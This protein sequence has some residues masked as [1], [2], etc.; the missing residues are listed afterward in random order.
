MAGGADIRAGK[1]FVEFY[2]KNASFTKGI[3]AIQGQIRSFGAGLGTIGK[4]MMVAGLAIVAPILAATKSWAGAGDEMWRLSKTTG[5]AVEALSSLKFAANE[6]SV[7]T[8]NLAKA[9]PKM[10]KFMEEAAHGG[11]EQIETLQQLGLRMAD[12]RAMTPDEQFRAMAEAISRIQNPTL[13]VAAA[14]KVF[15]KSGAELLPMFAAGRAGIE[16]YEEEARNLGLVM[17]GPAAQAAHVLNKSLGLIPKVIA[18][19]SRSIGSVLAP[20][21]QIM[22]DRIVKALPGFRAWINEHKKMV[23]GIAA[24]AFAFA[25]SGAGLFILGK[26]ISLT[27]F[28][29]TP[30]KLLI[31]VM[32]GIFYALG[33][34][35]GVATAAFGFLWGAVKMILSPIGKVFSLLASGAVGAVKLFFSLLSSGA[36]GGVKA[37][38]LLASGVVGAVKMFWNLGSNVAA[39]FGVVKNIILRVANEIADVVITL[40]TSPFKFFANL[41]VG[42]GTMATTLGTLF[43]PLAALA[44]LLASCWSAV[45]A[46]ASGF[47]GFGKT[48]KTFAENSVASVSDGLTSMRTGAGADLTQLRGA[49]EG[50]GTFFAGWSGLLGRIWGDVTAAA[51]RSYKAFGEAIAGMQDA[52]LA[53]DWASMGPILKNTLVIAWGEIANILGKNWGSLID[54]LAKTGAGLWYAMSTGIAWVLKE[55]K[56]GWA[57]FVVVAKR[58]WYEMLAGVGNL[59]AKIQIGLLKGSAVSREIGLAMSPITEAVNEARGAAFQEIKPGKGGG[60]SKS[61]SAY[62]ATVGAENEAFVSGAE[63]RFADAQAAAEST[64]ARLKDLIGKPG[65]PESDIEAARKNVTAA[66]AQAKAARDVADAAAQAK[67]ARDVAA[68]QKKQQGMELPAEAGKSMTAGTF[69]GY[70]LSMMGMGGSA[71]DRTAAA[72]ERSR[73]I[74]KRIEDL[75]GK[76][77]KTDVQFA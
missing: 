49:F 77:M 44:L 41:I 10:A 55:L 19:I 7:E 22:I 27:T 26:A 16:A 51:Q 59:L 74:L 62:E 70:A 45:K 54:Q 4:G 43:F 6:S 36:V 8:E 18:S 17:S 35:V 63:K 9:F 11:K 60:K 39:V 37:F 52:F 12:L 58:V 46:I 42:I 40:A 64:A 56:I 68:V 71:A 48:L 15:G 24:G 76:G 75:L 32:H 31:K 69:S 72:T 29:L 5:V 20:Y 66:A 61:Q 53:G 50:F 38:S 47:D 33:M 3:N 21:L 67:A 34:A 28:V 73:E 13:R 23:A 1:A 2:V 14:L 57:A 25:A 65:V 30:L